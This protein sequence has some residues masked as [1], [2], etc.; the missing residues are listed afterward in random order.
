MA[1]KKEM[2]SRSYIGTSVSP[3]M[4]Q[5]IKGVHIETGIGNAEYLRRLIKAEIARHQGSTGGGAATTV[6]HFASNCKEAT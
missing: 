1:R 3:E 4:L 6:A 5:Y 2:A